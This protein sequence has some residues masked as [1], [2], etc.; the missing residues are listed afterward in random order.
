[1]RK[2]KSQGATAYIALDILINVLQVSLQI[3]YAS[4]K[5]CWEQGELVRAEV[6]YNPSPTNLLRHLNYGL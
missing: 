6:K 1:M 2:S 4:C 3:I 5:L